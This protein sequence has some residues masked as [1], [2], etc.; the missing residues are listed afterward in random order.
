[1]MINAGKMIRIFWIIRIIGLKD[2]KYVAKTTKGFSELT[3]K[4]KR[5][6]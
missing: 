3:D 1:M 5:V 4:V 6:D 2:G